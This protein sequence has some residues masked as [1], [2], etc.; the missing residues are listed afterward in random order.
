M[1]AM[2]VV[3]DALSGLSRRWQRLLEL[4]L[5]DPGLPTLTYPISS[6]ARW[7][8]RS[9]R[10]RCVAQLRLLLQEHPP[11]V[12]TSGNWPPAVSRFQEDAVSR[13]PAGR[14][15][16]RPC[17]SRAWNARSTALARKASSQQH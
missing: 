3:H 14:S 1:N 6:G 2:K 5:S 16:V 8:D 4:L 15:N 17:P 11:S 9:H 13:P 10:G 7:Q 12:T